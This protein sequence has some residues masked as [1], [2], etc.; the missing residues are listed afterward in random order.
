MSSEENAFYAALSA[1]TRFIE[2]TDEGVGEPEANNG[3]G[4][5]ST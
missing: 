3:N 2:Q 1:I 4:E 5:A